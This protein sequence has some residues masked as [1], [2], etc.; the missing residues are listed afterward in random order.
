MRQHLVE[1][2]LNH[3]QQTR[4]L[5]ESYA[6]HRGRIMQLIE[7]TVADLSGASAGR[8]SSLVLL[9]AGNCLDVDLQQLTKL[10]QKIH[11]VD[12]D[13]GS[14]AAAADRNNLPP[15]SVELHAP[16]DI[17]EPLM[18][19]RPDDFEM[20]PDRRD[21]CTKVL[22]ALSAEH[23]ATEIPEADVV[24]SLCLLS[25]LIGTLEHLIHSSEPVS[26][27]AIKAVRVGHLRRMLNMLRPGGVAILVSDIVSS[28]T[29]P[30]LLEASDSQLPELLSRLISER[31]FFS[32]T[33]PS[34]MIN[35]LNILTRLPG[36]AESV[37]TIDPWLWQLGNRRYAVYGLRFQKVLPQ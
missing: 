9:G 35:E 15:E 20:T 30:E 2:H 37:E 1:E 11:L 28:E 16:V 10:F 22:Q 8:C 21:H 36:G 14:L 19:L 31:I 24:V 6:G 17:A 23:A 34:L 27:H 12:L 3:N 5:E 26:G 29:A 7:A 32:A 4:E 18:S 33:N 13:K 25:Q